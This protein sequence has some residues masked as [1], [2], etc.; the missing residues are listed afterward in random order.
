MLNVPDRVVFWTAARLMEEFKIKFVGPGWYERAGD[1]MLITD[2]GVES[3]HYFHCQVWNGQTID[4]LREQLA[5][6][7]A[8][9]VMM[10]EKIMPIC[11]DCGLDPSCEG[12]HDCHCVYENH[13]RI[14]IG[15]C[16][17]RSLGERALQDEDIG[18]TRWIKREKNKR[19]NA[20][21]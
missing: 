20:K 17:G 1:T 13:R 16:C 5:T 21:E 9:P 19:D 12:F 4:S 10:R 7:I 14:A 8:L 6:E 3:D 18:E 15:V 2:S 11:V